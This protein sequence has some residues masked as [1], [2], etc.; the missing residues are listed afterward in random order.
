MVPKYCCT[1]V[2][3]CTC[4]IGAILSE[5]A[6]LLGYRMRAI[7]T[8]FEKTPSH[9]FFQKNCSHNMM[10]QIEMQIIIH[11]Q[12]GKLSA[13]LFTQEKLFP[14]PF[15][16][17]SYGRTLLSPVSRLTWICSFP[18]FNFLETQKTD[19]PVPLVLRVTH[20]KTGMK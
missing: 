4:N 20:T 17:H 2:G 1:I 11:N 18:L 8:G 10:K 5:G 19:I 16:D 12:V 15:S 7:E 14:C 6:C 3:W 13:I 9:L